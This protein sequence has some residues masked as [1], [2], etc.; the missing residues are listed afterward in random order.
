MDIRP[1]TRDS[2]RPRKGADIADRLLDL[3]AGA[4]QVA[5]G[6]PEEPIGKHIARQLI[7]AGTSPA[8]NYEE[9][10]CAESRADFAHKVAVATKEVRETLYWLRLVDRMRLSAHPELKNHIDQADQLVAILTAS[11]ATA[12]RQRG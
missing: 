3:A 9:A 1:G 5:A 10:R 8:A 2:N 11:R 4:L 6:L 12:R 7:R